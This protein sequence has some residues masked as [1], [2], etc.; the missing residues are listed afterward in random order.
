ML[1][2]QA[3]V[4]GLLQGVTEFLPISSS[5]HLIV[6]PRLVGWTDPFLNSAAFD[7]M[8]H[9]GTLLA[10]LLF[11]WAELWRLLLAWLGSIRDLRVGA[12]P[13][14][15][16]S[17]FLLVTIIPGAV[18]GV[19]GEKY[20]DTYFR[21]H[22]MLIA[23]FIVLGAAALWLAEGL[24]ARRRDPGR[25]LGWIRLSDAVVMGAA[26][27]LALFPGISRSGI[28]IAG[29]LAMGLRRDAAARFSFLMSVPIIAGA[30][31]VKSR[32]LAGG[33]LA[34]SDVLP[35]LAGMAGAALAGVLSIKFLLDYLRRHTTMPFI[36]ERLV[37]AAV[38]VVFVLS[39]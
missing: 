9:A 4:I 27:A 1:T 18:L 15:R 11:F 10:L 3:F 6:F 24:A 29:G 22:L 36:I 28:T 2:L 8:L 13:E 26:Q 23:V 7:V 33:G 34:G 37:V 12:D 35:L 38:V 5:A 39:R 16:L 19:V 31:L 30:V 25:E 32:E 14:R 20:F 17:W 21:E